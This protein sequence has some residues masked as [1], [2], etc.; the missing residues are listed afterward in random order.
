[1]K[2]EL[3]VFLAVTL[4]VAGCSKNQESRESAQPLDYSAREAMR[5]GDAIRHDG[6]VDGQFFPVTGVITYDGKPL[7]D[8]RIRFQI[9]SGV[10]SRVYACDSK[11]DGSF[12]MKAD[13]SLEAKLGA[14]AGEYRVLVGK[15][16]G[17]PLP[18]AGDGDADEGAELAQIEAQ[19]ESNSNV[20]SAAPSR[21]HINE[22]FNNT[23]TTPLR[24]S[25]EAGDNSFAI[26]LKSDG[27]GTVT[28]R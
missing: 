20:L 23:S 16:K 3:T 18:V 12:Q 28:V 6:N 5:R 25:V 15:F 17:D 14:P 24:L 1:M 19:A 7:A 11:A 2:K 22:K 8:A 26:D 21:S 4:L 13:Y 9:A 10:A 27:T